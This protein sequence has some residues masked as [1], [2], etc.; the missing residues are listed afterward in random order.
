MP[1]KPNL[2]PEQLEQLKQLLMSKSAE[3]GNNNAIQP[4][5]K[6]SLGIKESV[7]NISIKKIFGSI[8]QAMAKSVKF[9]DQFT[10]FVVNKDTNTSPDVMNF[11]RKPIIFGI[12]VILFF[13]VGGFIWAATAPL[14]S[15]AVAIGT[16]IS[17]SK[18]KNINHQD[19]GVIKHIYVKL[20]DVV[21]KG[22][23][24]IEFEDNRIRAEYE[25]TLNQYR[26]YLANE[27]RLSAILL[28]SESI[29]YPEFLTQEITLPNVE[30][31]ISTQQNLFITKIALEKAEKESLEQAINQNK[32]QIE[33]LEA[34]KISFLKS[35]EV[36]RDRLSATKKLNAQGFSQKAALLELEAKEADA[37]S[38]VAMTETEI[39]RSEQAI[40]RTKIELLN[41]ESKHINETLNEQ[42]ET[43]INVS[44]LRERYLSQKD[45]LERVV[46][47]SP[48][49]GIVN[50]IHFY[51]IGSHIPPSTTIIEI[52]PNDDAL[53][54]EAKID[55]KN[56][57]SIRP[58]LVSKIRFSAFKSRTTPLFIGNLTSLSPDIVIPDQRNPIM[59]QKLAGGYYI[60]QIELNMSE[61]DEIAKSRN[62]KLV[63]G[64]QAEVQIVTGTRTL[65]QYLLDPIYDAMF[66]G[67]KEK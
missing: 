6:K 41:L 57:D 49:D 22:D 18:K 7:S 53:L 50:N 19:G 4:D 13:V 64:M 44:T 43:Q 47:R 55:P 39:S 40:T 10:D 1:K 9:I 37:V 32:K 60:A 34:Q 5:E 36:I 29:I 25:S 17:N 3:G 46:I 38:K 15:A 54:I 11:A 14:D 45:M 31:I 24:L 16:V 20:G 21:K 30:K 61:F 62:L 35:L 59:D 48:V 58:G 28:K 23:K 12:Y 26:T 33:G 52:S 51:T 56:I 42:K 65:L 63:P 8:L 67:F 27:A 2:T 66:K